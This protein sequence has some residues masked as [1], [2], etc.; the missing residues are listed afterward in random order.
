[1]PGRVLALASASAE[2]LRLALSGLVLPTDGL[3]SRSGLLSPPSSADL[4]AVSAMQAKVTPFRAWIDGGTTAAE[5]GYLF[6]LDAEETL[7][8]GNGLAGAVR[9]DRV[10]A[11]AAIQGVEVLPGDP[12]T[13]AATALPAG[14]LLLWEVPVPAGASAGGGGLNIA[15]IRVDK[16]PYTTAT[17]GIVPVKDQADR[18][19]LTKYD[20]LAVYRRDTDAVEIWDGSGWDSFY[21]NP[22]SGGGVMA[23]TTDA[24]GYLIVTHGLGFT[25]TRVLVTPTAPIAGGNIFGQ[26]IADSFTA[27]TFRVRCIGHTG[28]AF[29]ALAVVASWHAVK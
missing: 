3:N 18:D 28:V 6:T 12:A 23:G 15:G 25:P 8:F 19:A 22:Q 1:M 9:T 17:G 21:P 20:G 2:D 11:R 13:G 4:V 14:S 5:G 10:I 7:A 24:N 26:A 16:R 29:N 27:T